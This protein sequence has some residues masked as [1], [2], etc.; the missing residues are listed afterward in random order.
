MMGGTLN[1]ACT[2]PKQGLGGW[3]D[4]EMAWKQS[5]SLADKRKKQTRDGEQKKTTKKKTGS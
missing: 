2:E 1:A 5:Q 4:G 3:R